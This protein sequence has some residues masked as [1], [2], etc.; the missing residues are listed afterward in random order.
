M[1]VGVCLLVGLTLCVCV[2]LVQCLCFY[3]SKI[4]W[5]T[6]GLAFFLHKKWILLGPSG[7]PS[8]EN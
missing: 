5:I 6:G 3:Y 8:G 2:C 4:N 1:C 7:L